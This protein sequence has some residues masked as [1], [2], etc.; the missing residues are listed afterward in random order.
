MQRDSVAIIGAGKVGTATGHLLRSRGYSVVA[1]ADISEEAVLRALEYTGGRACASA[2]EAAG[3]AET[4]FITTTDDVISAVCHDIAEQ[5]VLGPGKRVVHMSGAGG[6]DLLE[7]ALRTGASA[8]TIHP[9]QSFVDVTAV[10]DSIPGSTFAITA[11]DDI[12]GWAVQVV[13]DLGGIPFFVEDADKP[14]YHAAAC[15]AS[16]YLV[17]LMHIVTSLY[18]LLGFPPGEATRAFWPLVRGTITNMEAK[19]IDRALT[20]P[21]A[22]G[23]VLTIKKHLA[24][25]E[26]RA[27]EFLAIY[28]ELGFVAADL[29]RS[30]ETISEEKKEELASLLKGENHH[31]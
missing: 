22:R 11:Q 30:M 9:L 19:G 1:V 14:L 25:L 26:A 15:V 4:V 24:V 20:G 3:L 12:R 6:L 27:P 2:A 18:G 17:S 10:I 8:A 29:A 16:N 21:I 5:G 23:D 7:P 28:R 13:T 31:E